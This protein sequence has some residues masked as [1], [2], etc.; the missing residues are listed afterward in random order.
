[1]ALAMRFGDTGCIITGM[2][3]VS[4]SFTS[5]LQ[6]RLLTVSIIV[7]EAVHIVPRAHQQWYYRNDMTRYNWVGGRT[8]VSDPAN[9]LALRLDVGR[10]WALNGFLLF[11][12]PGQAGFMT[13]VTVPHDDDI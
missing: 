13:Y 6:C 8:G 5:A 4:T 3:L 1:M 10:L 12:A 7:Y 9:R 11:P 2:S